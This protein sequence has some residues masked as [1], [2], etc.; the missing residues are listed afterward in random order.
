M[1]I[2]R[3][4]QHLLTLPTFEERFKYLKLDG[5][6]GQETFGFDRYFNQK[7][8]RSTEW[9]QIRNF[10][11]ARDQG[12]DLAIFDRQIFGRVYVHH[13]NPIS[14]EDIKD[15]TDF[16]LNPDYLVCVSK[17]T[18]DA[19]HYGDGSLLTPTKLTERSPG[20]TKLW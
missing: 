16:L 3:T 7:F 14:L 20:D 2:L 9:K 4:Y 19:I 5:K 13:M 8:Y 18:H 6:V 17:E 11:I 12:C 10:V 15:A 1:D